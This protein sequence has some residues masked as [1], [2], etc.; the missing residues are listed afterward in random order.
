VKFSKSSINGLALRMKTYI[1]TEDNNERG[2]GR[3]QVE[4][5]PKGTKT[6][7][8]QYFIDNKKKVLNIGKHPAWS[9]VEAREKFT[10]YSKLVGHGID[11]KHEL[12]RHRQ[13]RLEIDSQATIQQL[14]KD[15]QTNGVSLLATTTQ[16]GYNCAID[17]ILTYLP[18][19]ITP[20]EFIEQ[21]LARHVIYS[22]YKVSTNQYA[23]V[24]KK[25]M[26]SA[27]KWAINFDN[28][29]D[30]YQLPGRYNVKYN[31]VRDVELIVE[32]NPGERWL[33]AEEIR[34]LWHADD[35]KSFFTHQFVKLNLAMAGQRM[36]EIL[37]GV[38]GEIDYKDSIFTIPRERI[39]IKARQDHIVPLSDLAISIL[40]QQQAIT[41]HT[42]KLFPGTSKRGFYTT[43]AVR[44]AL[45]RF[46][47]RHEL[48]PFTG[49]DLRRTCKT[50]MSKAGISKDDRDRL[51]QHYKDDV[52]TVHY[53][54]Y[55]YMKEKRAA[56]KK[57]TTYLKRI[58]KK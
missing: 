39:K 17:R 9:L 45:Q 19:P 27:F 57:W 49:R 35:F 48:A 3:F 4:V 58:T 54:R 36:D 2:V 14:F 52:A 1:V 15:Y 11:P 7:R 37:L 23:G 46:Y 30:R 26:K 12:Q 24:I 42:N 20:A 18:S 10:E 31:P 33:S 28:S 29:P 47:E 21:D 56:M 55:D 53:D 32:K 38:D 25:V 5:T 6:F 22:V 44:A 40:E 50:H 13:N 43:D 41:T 34:L 51:Q 16:K 8:I